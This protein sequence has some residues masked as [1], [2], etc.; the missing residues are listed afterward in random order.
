MGFRRLVVLLLALALT[1]LSFG[2]GGCFLLPAE[3]AVLA[4]PL[5]EPEEIVYKTEPVMRGNMEDKRIITAYFAP[6]VSHSLY[7]TKASGRVQSIDIALGKEVEA[8]DILVE[9]E[10]ENIQRRIR[11]QELVVKRLESRLNEARS[12]GAD[13]YAIKLAQLDLEAANN[14]YQ[15]LLAEKTEISTRHGVDTNPALQEQLENIDTK[16]RDQLIQ[17]EKL[18]LKLEQL[19]QGGNSYQV[20]QAAYELES[21]EN[22]L[23]DLYAEYENTVLRAPITGRITWMKTMNVGES[24][25]TYSSIITLSDPTQL[26]LQYDNSKASEFPV[27]MKVSIAY[28]K[29]TYTGTVESNPQTNPPSENGSKNDYARFTI[30][31]FDLST[32][33]AG[34]S[35]QITAVLDSREDV[36]VISKNRVNTFQTRYYVNV[37]VD[38][39][40]E[41]RDIQ[42][43]LQTA[44]EVEVLK[45]LE[46]GELIIIN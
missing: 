13:E 7:F 19:E 14:V 44:T 34:A 17:L 11:D 27:G 22:S 26:V 29:E 15:D 40:K 18:Q 45:G 41:E 16:M 30:D 38:G 6:I 31:G 28:E 39:I 33:A 12:G 10:N 2:L 42:I 32:A 36:I 4:P 43:G 8:G 9:L 46:E 21:A 24:V 1:A 25:G 37:L 5:V 20:E 35:A 3:E 23:N